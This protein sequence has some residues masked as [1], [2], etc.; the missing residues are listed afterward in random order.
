MQKFTWVDAPLLLIPGILLALTA[1]SW[2]GTGAAREFA[3]WA[4]TTYGIYVTA[5]ATSRLLLPRRARSTIV[6]VAIIPAALSFL[7]GGL[8]LGAEYAI[9]ALVLAPLFGVLF[10]A[11]FL[12]AKRWPPLPVTTA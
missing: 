1:M 6:A 10:G 9:W 5:Y 11:A 7:A 3:I 4:L 2:R 8:S 12:P